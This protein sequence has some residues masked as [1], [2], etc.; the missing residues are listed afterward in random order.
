MKQPFMK[1]KQRLDRMG[2]LRKGPTVQPQPTPQPVRQA[3]WTCDACGHTATRQELENNLLVCP[4]CGA[5]QPMPALRRLALVLDEG[6]Q[7]VDEP[8][9]PP[10]P[11][12][13]PDYAAKA[14]ANR[15]KTGLDEAAIT[16]VGKINGRKA[17]VSVLDSS[18]LMGSM[19]MVVGERV[20][21]AVEYAGRARL[22]ILI[23]SASGGARMQEGI[24]ALMQMAKTAAAVEQFSR[25]GGLYISC[26]THPTTGG[27]SASFAALGDIILAEPG[28]LVGFAGPR[29]IRQTIGQELPEG[30]QRAEFLEEHG[31]VDQIVPR[32]RLK[33]VLTQLL[34]LHDGKGR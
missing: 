14:A 15:E 19:G 9:L 7:L 27:V 33:A 2:Q 25:S 4:S 31:F 23:F 30:F 1:K 22:P 34:M 28:A 29:V 24:L 12:E 3:L 5:H 18:F 32:N 8:L 11:L 17:V 13:F 6:W 10:D 20:C 16:A 21:R 26:L